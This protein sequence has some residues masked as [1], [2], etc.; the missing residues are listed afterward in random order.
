MMKHTQT[1]LIILLFG[2]FSAAGTTA[3]TS[4]PEKKLSAKSSLKLADYL[5]SIGSY[6]NAADYY[7]KVYE[8]EDKNSYAV[9][10]IAYC[11]FY[12]RD[13]KQAEQW[14]KTLKDMNAPEYPMAGYMYATC[15]KM[16]SKY[17]AAKS[18]FDKYLNFKG[19]NA[20]QIK[21]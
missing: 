21:K 13:Y 3:Q 1:L 4:Q 7:K 8:K 10:Q 5:F 2:L 15:L 9:N 16:N 20:S 11:E 17:P 19:Q 6:F 14:F 18:E 12:L